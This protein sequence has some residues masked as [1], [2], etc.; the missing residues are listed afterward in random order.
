MVLPSAKVLLSPEGLHGWAHNSV[1]EDMLGIKLV[2]RVVPAQI[3]I[4]GRQALTVIEVV[5]VTKDGPVSKAGIA[6]KL[7]LVGLETDSDDD[8]LIRGDD[9]ARRLSRLRDEETIR[10]RVFDPHL[11]GNTACQVH[12]VDPKAIGSSTSVLS[13]IADAIEE[14]KDFRGRFRILLW[15]FLVAL[16]MTW[17]RNILRFCQ[18]YLVQTSVFMGIRDLRCENYA[19]VLRLPMTFFSQHGTSDTMSRFLNDVGELSRGQVTLFGKTLVEPAKAA[20]SLTMALVFSWRLTLLALIAGPPAFFLIRQFGRVM[21]KASRRALESNALLVRALDETLIGMRVVKAYTM[22]AAERK[23]FY[24]VNR[25]LIKQ[26]R[27]M[28]RIDS[29]TAPSVEAL[30]MTAAMG[31]AA[32]AGWWVFEGRMDVERFLAMMICLAAMFDPV[33]KLAK[34]ATRFQRAEAAAT[35]VFELHDQPQERRDLTAPKLPRH[36]QAIELRGVS[37]R[38]PAAEADAVSNVD[39]TIQHNETIAIVGPNGCGKTTLVSLLP[40]LLEPTSGQ[41]FIDG[42]DIVAASLR[43]LRRQIGLVTQETILFHATIR[44]NISYGL[45]SPDDEAVF[46][47]ARRAYVDE[48]VGEMPDGYETMVGEHGATLSGGQ[49]QRIAI[50]RAILR[51]PSILIFDEA[52]S[53][54]DADSEHR[55]HQAMEQFIEGR[56]TI[57]IAHRFATIMSADRIVVMDG[58]RIIDV[59]HHDDLMPRCELYAHLYRTQ[60][61]DTGG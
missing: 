60:F 47:A 8:Q 46:D 30:G 2:Q 42:Q 39:L 6:D 52:T 13:R 55:I 25:K 31:A 18:E 11:P 48:F 14:P 58:G 23:R 19:V 27:R 53:Q 43:S 54:I 15:L 1:T 59:G 16:G 45:L 3:R 49:R 20:A 26:L 40:R 12:T 7:W 36:S 33:R 38:Y 56:T 17:V 32:L 34:V 24:R 57:M 61:A 22:E 9:L 35:R 21:K 10:L 41:I 44:E 5:T 4:E 51:D 29:I 50:A 28:A 37:F